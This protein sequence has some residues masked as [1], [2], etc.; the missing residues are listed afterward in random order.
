MRSSLFRIEFV[1]LRKVLK[2]SRV[3]NFS[4]ETHLKAAIW[5]HTV[6]PAI[7]HQ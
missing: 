3:Y 6:L 1:T 2:V 7:R 5:D 4:W